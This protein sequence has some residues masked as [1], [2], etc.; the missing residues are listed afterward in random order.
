MRWMEGASVGFAVRIVKDS[1]S[2]VVVA[3]APKGFEEREFEQ[4]RAD[5]LQTLLQWP[6][7]TGTS[8]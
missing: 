8:E 3:I 2:F 1:G 6:T 7:K 5:Y 4:K